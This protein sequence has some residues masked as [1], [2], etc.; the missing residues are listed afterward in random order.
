MRK[1][2]ALLSCVVIVAGITLMCV[3][4]RLAMEFADS[5]HYTEKDKR[6]YEYYTP[7]L[8]RKMPRISDDYEFSYSRIS[9]PDAVVYGV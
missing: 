2:L 5:A 1:S 7:D 6:E 3:W 4:P 8:L 9:G